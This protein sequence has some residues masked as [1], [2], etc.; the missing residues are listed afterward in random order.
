MCLIVAKFARVA[1]V[2]V[3]LRTASCAGCEGV[4]DFVCEG[5]L[6]LYVLCV[7]CVPRNTR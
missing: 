3:A 1:R 4:Q 5:S 2:C 6:Q 7:S